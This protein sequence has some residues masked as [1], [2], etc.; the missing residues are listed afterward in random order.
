MGEGSNNEFSWDMVFNSD[1]KMTLYSLDIIDSIIKTPTSDI[2]TLEMNLRRNW[3]ERF[4]A[5]GGFT[6]L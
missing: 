3:V 1:I 6:Q 4:L 2:D 5:K